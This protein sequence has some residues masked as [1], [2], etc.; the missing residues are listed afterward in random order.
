MLQ[1]DRLLPFLCVYRRNPRRR[2]EGT[3]RLVMSEAS[4]LCAPGTL[5]R[6]GLKRLIRRIA[7]TVIERL[8]SF[9]ILEVWPGRMNAA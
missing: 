3:A 1:M 2:D 8:G 4:F 9:L 5:E 7:E 6:T